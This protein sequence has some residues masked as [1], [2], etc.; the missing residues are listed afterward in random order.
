LTPEQAM[1]KDESNNSIMQ[2][3]IHLIFWNECYLARLTCT[4]LPKFER[5]NK[6]T[7][8][9]V[10]LGTKDIDWE[11]AKTRLDKVLS[12]F[13]TAVKNTDEENLNSAA[14]ENQPDSWYSY[15]AQIT[16]HNSYHIGQIVTIRKHH[17]N[18][19]SEKGFK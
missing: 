4:K 17:G 16:V 18:W 7:F 6:D 2:I 5:D 12:D 10:S 11:S 14:V 1:Q 3:V 19:D 8:E 9:A 15:L 13:Y